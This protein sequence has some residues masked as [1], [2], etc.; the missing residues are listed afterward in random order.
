MIRMEIPQQNLRFS[1]VVMFFILL[2]A[3][4][5]W[6]VRCTYFLS[7]P[8]QIKVI[9]ATGKEWELRAYDKEGKFVGQLEAH[10]FLPGIIEISNIYVNESLRQRGM[11][12]HLLK[13]F[14]Q[15]IQGKNYIIGRHLVED[16]AK[17]FLQTYLSLKDPLSKTFNPKMTQEEAYLIALKQTPSYKMSEALGLDK[18]AKLEVQWYKLG[19]TSTDDVGIYVE[20]SF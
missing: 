11:G 19:S 16:N 5:A 7:Q 1:F 6:G 13:A 15:Q 3:P 2:L 20:M 4:P 14:M 18:V 10:M 17:V 12:Q 8:P 9:E